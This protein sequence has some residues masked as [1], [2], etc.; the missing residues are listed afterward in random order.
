MPG[1]GTDK[2]YRATCL[3]LWSSLGQSGPDSEGDNSKGM[4]AQM[5]GDLSEYKG[6]V[7]CAKGS[8]FLL[9]VGMGPIYTKT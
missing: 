4:D 7:T 1:I 2:L 8:Y 5:Q 3:E 9:E 6:G